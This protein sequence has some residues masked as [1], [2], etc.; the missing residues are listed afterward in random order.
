MA[1]GEGMAVS[2]AAALNET[3]RS[4][5]DMQAGASVRTS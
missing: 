2:R 5:G 3:F 4:Y 1:P